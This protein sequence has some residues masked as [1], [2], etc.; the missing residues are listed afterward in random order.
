MFFL[1][2][3]THLAGLIAAELINYDE[4]IFPNAKLLFSV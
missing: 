3:G 2:G 1:A 4:S